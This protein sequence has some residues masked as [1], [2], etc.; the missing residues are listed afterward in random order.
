[1]SNLRVLSESQDKELHPE[2]ELNF[3]LSQLPIRIILPSSIAP[4]HER[5][6]E[7]TGPSRLSKQSRVEQRWH[8][9]TFNMML[10]HW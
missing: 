5:S 9:E 3:S 8:G 2:L 10:V 1:M 7:E 6:Q 4:L